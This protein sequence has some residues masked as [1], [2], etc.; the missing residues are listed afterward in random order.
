[1][2]DW[3]PSWTGCSA[4]ANYRG[5]PLKDP[6][7]W[8]ATAF[9]SVLGIV[10]AFLGAIGPG[11]A[12]TLASLTLRAIQFCD[13][14]LN[15]RLICLGGDRS[16]VGVI[17]HLEPP[18]TPS[19]TDEFN[20]GDYDTDYSFNLLLWPFAPADVLPDNFVANEWDP[21][22]VDGD[23]W[24]GVTATLGA[25][26]SPEVEQQVDRIIPQQSMASLGLGLTGEGIGDGKQH[27]LLHCEIEGPG[28]HDLVV[29][30]EVLLGIFTAML[31]V[32]AIP[33]VGTLVSLLIML[34]VILIALF[35]GHEIISQQPTP[36]DTGGWGGTFNTV[37]GAGS[38]DAPVDMGYMYGR[39]VYDS[40]H[41]GGNELHP[42]HYMI[43]MGEVTKGEIVNGKWP[44]GVG[45]LQQ[46][47]DEAF[48][49]ISAPGAAVLQ[50]Q[51]QNG[52]TLHPLLDGC[53]GPTPY[54]DPPPPVVIV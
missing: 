18:P 22:A 26:P 51:P 11:V 35:A 10:A 48:G 27:Y 34:A 20:L 49:A 16:A 46:R 4:P 36:P 2:P 14:W 30:L 19:A 44:S 39:W 31:F 52:W 24:P 47:Y 6:A 37:E 12:W 15:V 40:F 41:S 28:M 42:I 53:Q 50:A 13:W 1:M 38:D 23:L 17:Y 29:L 3:F 25:P 9:T 8:F 7:F 5:S 21:S 45:Q 54:P 43:K 32:S 33:G